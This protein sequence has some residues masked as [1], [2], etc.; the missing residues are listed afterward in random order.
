MFRSVARPGWPPAKRTTVTTRLLCVG[1]L[2]LGKRPSRT[3]AGA[4]A[5]GATPERLGPA[6]A[7]RRCVEY[8]KSARV[9]AVLLAGDVV[10]RIEDRFAAFD[11]LRR[12]VEE[13]TRAGIQVLGVTGN[14]DVEALPRL[15]SLLPEFRLLGRGGVWEEVPLAGRDGATVLGWSFPAKQHHD[16][17]LEGLPQ[18]RGNGLRIGLLHGDLDATHSPYA[19]VASSELE[20]ADAD[21]WLLGHVHTPSPLSASKP[22]GYLGSVVALD[23]SES[24]PRGPW[25]LTIEKGALRFEHLPLA[26]LRYEHVAIDLMGGDLL[27]ALDRV[28]REVEARVRDSGATPHVVGLRG[29]LT[30]APADPRELERDL[31]RLA[32]EPYEHSGS[33]QN[34]SAFLVFVDKLIDETR[35]PLDIAAR[36]ERGDHVG[37]V[38]RRVTVLERGG[39]AANDVLRAARRALG[40]DI[41]RLAQRLG[42]EDLGVTDDVLARALR[43]AG[44]DVAQRLVEQVERRVTT[45]AAGAPENTTEVNRAE[46]DA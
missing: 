38:A 11:A 20:L 32:T 7:W 16:S 19:P 17:P 30:G 13:L 2:H 12:G 39:A 42:L 28:A 1:D 9:D 23:P 18:R 31:A 43:R 25:L 3:P 4:A 27:A 22:R 36:A 24:G 41:A 6:A 14:H 15:A 21:A 5:I 37:L 8:A 10:E 34:G 26:P 46:V 35:P 44:L 45:P 33:D 29:M 40:D